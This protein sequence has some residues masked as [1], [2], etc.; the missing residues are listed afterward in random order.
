MRVREGR[1]IEREG[2][3]KNKEGGRKRGK[4]PGEMEGGGG[5]AGFTQRKE[6]GN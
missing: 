6:S 1:R 4:W 2:W 5:G 3:E